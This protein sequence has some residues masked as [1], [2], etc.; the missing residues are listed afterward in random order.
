MKWELKI[1]N[2]RDSAV[3]PDFKREIQVKRRGKILKDSKGI[4]ERK[5]ES[6]VS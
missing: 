5:N 3:L 2:K 4:S 6:L 1:K